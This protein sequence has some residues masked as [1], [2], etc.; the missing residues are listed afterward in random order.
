MERHL[1]S[2]C[3]M[4]PPPPPPPQNPLSNLFSQAQ[5][6][7]HQVMPL[8]EAEYELSQILGH[9]LVATNQTSGPP[10]TYY[11]GDAADN[12]SSAQQPQQQN[13][14]PQTVA[15]VNLLGT[16]G[17]LQLEPNGSWEVF[18]GGALVATAGGSSAGG[19]L[20]QNGNPTVLSG[21]GRY[22]VAGEQ[23]H[24]EMGPL[25]GDNANNNVYMM[26]PGTNTQDPS[27][28]MLFTC[29]GAGTNY[30]PTCLQ[31]A[32]QL[33]SEHPNVQ[34][35]FTWA[36]VSYAGAAFPMAPSI[37][38]GIAN[39]AGMIAATPGTFA[40][41]G[42]SEGAIVTCRIWRDY[43]LNP[44]GELHDRLGDIIGHVTWGNPMRCPGIANGNAMAGL[45]AA[46][47]GRLPHRGHLPGPTT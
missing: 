21:A 19:S 7:L 30:D 3:D 29:T 14:G 44:E 46:A 10:A 41:S 39:L 43:I 42:F 36:G 27:K 9:I 12:P 34:Q 37:D 24:T 23:A 17:S 16:S 18:V 13:T 31:W 40:L 5:Q 32:Y 47:A 25:V 38:E 26:V 8:L 22:P 11:I 28:H 33:Y 6:F 4:P 1:L 20:V 35:T 15:V 45:D 2:D